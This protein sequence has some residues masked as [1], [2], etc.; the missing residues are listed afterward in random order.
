MSLQIEEVISLAKKAGEKILEIYHDGAKAYRK[1]DKSPVTEA[2]FA[3]E[4][5]LLSQLKE[6]G[7]GILSEETED[8]L[9]RLKKDKIWII[10]PLDGTQDFLQKTG[11]FSIMV[12][13]V[14][15]REPVLGVVYKPVGDKMYFAERGK[16][17]FLK[18]A[19]KPLQKLKVSCISS[20]SNAHFVITRSHFSGAEERFIQTYKIK[21]VTLMGSIGVKLG[22][23]AEGKADCYITL[24]D[25]TSQWDICAPQII[26]EEAGGRVT[27]T[28][29]KSFVYNRKD[30]KNLNGILASNGKIHDEIIQ[31]LNS[32]EN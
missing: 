11:E 4:K 27:D 32:I 26:L 19:E 3:S 30:I 13:L 6:S 5:I 24:S 23:I 28:K 22:L 16:G 1:K 12:G 9:S 10:D 8:D 18:E 7:Y 31:K 15:R 29:G 20:L 2:D 25:K 14:K 21:K 17:A